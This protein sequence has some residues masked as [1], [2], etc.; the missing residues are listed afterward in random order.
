MLLR[1]ISVVESKEAPSG[2]FTFPE[3]MREMVLFFFFPFFFLG[4]DPRIRLYVISFTHH[5]DS[6]CS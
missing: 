3:C 1:Y 5:F 4:C 6:M 2:T